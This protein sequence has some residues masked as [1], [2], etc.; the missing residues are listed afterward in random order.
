MK[1][2]LTVLVT[3]AAVVGLTVAT[4]PEA[5]AATRHGVRAPRPFA[6]RADEFARIFVAVTNRYASN[7]GD[8]RRIG[9]ADCLRAAPGRYMCSYTAWVAG[10]PGRCYL[11]QARWTP[12]ASSTITITLAG[13]VDRCSSLRAALDSL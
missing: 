8:R 3:L 6:P 10:S 12:R 5:T 2:R 9:R 1:A 11:M 4:A 13:R 7:H